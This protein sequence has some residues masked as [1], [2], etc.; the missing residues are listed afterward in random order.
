MRERSFRSQISLGLLA[1]VVLAWMRPP[2]LWCALS[3]LAAGLVLVA[4]MFNTA[5]EQALDR[6]H[7]DQHEGIRIAKDC[8]A[9]AVLLATLVAICVGALTVLAGF[10]LV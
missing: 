5:L 9:G 8:A 7:P 10:G 1:L 2:A 3:L 6:L 4:E